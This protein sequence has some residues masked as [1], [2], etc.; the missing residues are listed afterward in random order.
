[1]R[2]IPNPNTELPVKR[3]ERGARTYKLASVS[4]VCHSRA[5]GSLKHNV[6]TPHE[7]QCNRNAA[8]C[9]VASHRVASRGDDQVSPSC[10]FARIPCGSRRSPNAA[11]N[12]ITYRRSCN[13]PICSFLRSSS[14]IADRSDQ[15]QANEL[16]LYNFRDNDLPFHSEQRAAKLKET[17][18]RRR[19]RQ[20]K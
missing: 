2:A 4:N 19:R 3:W 20:T 9:R 8:S 18:A 6:G 10:G 11:R 7:S 14:I 15:P 1:M 17:A 13:P 5:F 12:A 16:I